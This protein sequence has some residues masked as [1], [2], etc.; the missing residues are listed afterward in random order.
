MFLEQVVSKIL[1]LPFDLIFI[2]FT[3]WISYEYNKKRE[4][5]FY[6]EALINEVEGDISQLTENLFNKDLDDFLNKRRLWL[7]K[8][9][10]IRVASGLNEGYLYQYLLDHAYLIFVNKGYVIELQNKEY[11]KGGV[12]SHLAE[13]YLHCTKFNFRSFEI[14]NKIV[15]KKAIL[16]QINDSDED[17]QKL[18]TLRGMYYKTL[19]TTMDSA[20]INNLKGIIEK[21]E[22]DK[23]A[24]FTYFFM[25][26]MLIIVFS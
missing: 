5:I 24:I 6:L 4:L 18:K 22:D 17:I 8:G 12:F 13:F 19:T 10:S 25:L 7:S 20:N 11:V 23:S 2:I 16:N 14:E 26:V 3:V 1:L 21:F 9:I 15:Q